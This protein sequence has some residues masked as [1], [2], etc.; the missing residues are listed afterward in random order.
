LSAETSK[1]LIV[2]VDVKNIAIVV[3]S[4]RTGERDFWSAG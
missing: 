2:S 3:P 4:K 1:R